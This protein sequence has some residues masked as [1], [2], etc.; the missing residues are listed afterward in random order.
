MD[1]AEL[2]V[3]DEATAVMHIKVL[4][5]AVG[6]DEDGL[7]VA[8]DGAPLVA[9]IPAA[10]YAELAET[11]ENRLWQLCNQKTSSRIDRP[12]SLALRLIEQRKAE[13]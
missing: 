3:I 6:A 1:P 2:D 7:I 11:R 13:S 8:R 12:V 9:I 4:L 10:L 5:D